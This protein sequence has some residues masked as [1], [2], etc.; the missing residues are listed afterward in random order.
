MAGTL[1]A[2]GSDNLEVDVPIPDLGRGAEA[3][4]R[5][6]AFCTEDRSL[7]QEIRDFLST[8]KDESSEDFTA[9]DAPLTEAPLP[10]GLRA[11]IV[12]PTAVAGGDAVYARADKTGRQVIVPHQVRDLITR[13]SVTLTDASEQ[14]LIAAVAATFHDML[15]IRLVNLGTANRIVSIRDA[16]AGTVRDT[17]LLPATST[18]GMVFPAPFKQTTSNNAWTAQLDGAPVGGNVFV[19]AQFAENI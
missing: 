10:M 17:W 14:S 8:I 3:L 2:K 13:G 11:S 6:V 1:K 7:M 18:D 4:A 16:T 15:F 12:N 19:I 5:S 9:N